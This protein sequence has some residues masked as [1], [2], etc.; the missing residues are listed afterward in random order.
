MKEITFI[1]FLFN[2]YLF[3][4]LGVLIGMTIINILRNSPNHKGE[5]NE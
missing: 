1:E 4:T 5:K 3:Y 2:N